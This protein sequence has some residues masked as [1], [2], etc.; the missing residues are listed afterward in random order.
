MKSNWREVLS[1]AEDVNWDRLRV[2]FQ[3]Q[4]QDWA[5]NYGWQLPHTPESLEAFLLD[6]QELVR[7]YI[8]RLE[9]QENE[10]W[11]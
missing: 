2:K 5:I 9:D 10:D 6:K 4:I 1:W 3:D 7:E 11:K 8:Q